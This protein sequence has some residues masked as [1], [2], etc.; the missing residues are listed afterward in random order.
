[1][2]HLTVT[3]TETPTRLDLFLTRSLPGCSRRMAQRAIA[4]GQVVVNGFPAR[5]GW[6][7]RPGDVV[8]VAD[9]LL[10]P[11]AL[12]PNSDLEVA[13]LY[14]DAAIVALD[15]PAGI[16][17]HA[18]D[19]ADT[20]SVANFLLARYPETAQVGRTPLEPGV[21]HRLD[22]GTS[23]VLLVARTPA[24]YTELRRQF[25]ERRIRKEYRALV[26]GAVLE[27]GEVR[28]PLA[29]DRHNRR[30]M[31][32]VSPASDGWAA[33]TRFRPIERSGAFTLLAVEIPTG[34]T[35]QIRVHLASIG[36]PVV[37]DRLYGP[38][39]TGSTPGRQLLHAYRIEF[40]HPSDR[41]PMVVSS[42]LPPDVRRFLVAQKA[43]QVPRRK[44]GRPTGA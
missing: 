24:A 31:R 23:G 33:I 27:P 5:K 43:G 4:L 36:F 13:I 25:A 42:R 26:H 40:T 15:K 20:V 9:S 37:G 29:H 38:T 2:P 39:P 8:E 12:A 32:V 3:A 17:S 6:S 30:K 28:A 34:V 19:P 21:V 11:A 18:L 14:E 44:A 16:P 10:V 1:M 7:V 35:H 22:T 41:R